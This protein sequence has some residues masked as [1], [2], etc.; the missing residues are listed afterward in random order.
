MILELVAIT[1]ACLLCV[2]TGT[3][4]LGVLFGVTASAVALIPLAIK[5]QMFDFTG[6][7]FADIGHFIFFQTILMVGF[8]AVG[9]LLYHSQI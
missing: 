1:L 2:S 6:D 3:V 8:I 4:V 5:Y 7:D 9:V